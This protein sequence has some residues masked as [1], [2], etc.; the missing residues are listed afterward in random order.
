MEKRYYVYI[1]TNKPRGILYIGITN[2]IERRIYEHKNKLIEGFSKK[3]SLDKLVYCE[4]C[5]DVYAAIKREK[6][7][8]KWNRLWKIELIESVN[9]NW[10]DLY[11]I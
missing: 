8:K 10:E 5:D 7:L 9:P 4:C 2:S 11:K 3:Y 1:I 6:M